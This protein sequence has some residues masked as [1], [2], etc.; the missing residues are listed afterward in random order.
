VITDKKFILD[1]IEKHLNLKQ[2]WSVGVCKIRYMG[3]TQ[4]ILQKKKTANYSNSNFHL[5]HGRDIY[6]FFLVC[7]S[8]IR[9]LLVCFQQTRKKNSCCVQQSWKKTY[10]SSS[11]A[12]KISVRVVI[13]G[14]FFF[15]SIFLAFH[16]C[17]VKFLTSRCSVELIEKDSTDIANCIKTFLGHNNCLKVIENLYMSK[18]LIIVKVTTN[19]N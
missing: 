13:C 15:F 5:K 2:I 4:N 19:W 7:F 1:L 14:R 18:L 8:N 12:W 17:N 16:P 3:K 11:F 9:F 6:F 10:V